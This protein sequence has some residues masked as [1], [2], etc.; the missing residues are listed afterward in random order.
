MNPTE[1][2]SGN[3]SFREV[4]RAIGQLWWV[5]T[6]LIIVGGLAAATFSLLQTPQYEASATSYVTSGAGTEDAAQSAYQ[7]S[8]ASQQRVMSYTR[9]A[10][11]E[12]VVSQALKSSN[13]RLSVAD[14]VKRISATAAPDTVLLTINVSDPSREVAATLANAVSNSL[15]QYVNQLETPSG[16]GQPLAKVTLVSPAVVKPNPVTP[17]P[18]RN[19]ILGGLVG[20]IVG[21]CFIVARSILRNRVIDET[22]LSDREALSV[23][24][25]VPRDQSIASGSS[26]DFATGASTAVEAIR[27]IRTNLSFVN[28][29]TP[30]RTILVTSAGEKEGKTT[31]SL[32]LAA[33]LAEAEKRVLLVDG[34]FRRPQVHKRNGLVGKIGLT[35]ALRGDAEL[36]DVI[37]ESP[38]SGLWILAA[39]PTPPNPAELLGS[40][41]ASQV[42]SELAQWFDF[43]IIDSP[44]VL[45]V[46]DALVLTQWVDGIILVAR[47][48][49]VRKSDLKYALDELRRAEGKLLGYVLT[50]VKA[51]GSRYRYYSSQLN[52]K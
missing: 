51:S 12:A 32:N 31:L 28:V 22:D 41:R 33:A 29:D 10:S 5:V 40:Q 11:S 43:V 4:A 46:A 39:G 14:A 45:P 44:P 18:V 26:L 34:D 47:S 21:I 50:G 36:N 17:K 49:V 2:A 23:L 20:L 13:V 19:V 8:L 1:P 52:E 24:G 15:S 42:F 7:G 30:P 6:A 25:V 48:G 9:L 35:N 38:T 37:Q 3:E 16:G 27:K